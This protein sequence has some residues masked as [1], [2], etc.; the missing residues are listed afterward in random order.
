MRSGPGRLGR[1]TPFQVAALIIFRRLQRR[2][3]ATDEELSSMR[4]LGT[5]L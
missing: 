5:S 4:V 2:S 3:E 1:P